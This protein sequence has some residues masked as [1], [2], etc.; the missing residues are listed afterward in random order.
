MGQWDE[1]ELHSNVDSSWFIG[2]YDFTWV[3]PIH[4]PWVA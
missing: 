4:L 3:I 1:T 2:I